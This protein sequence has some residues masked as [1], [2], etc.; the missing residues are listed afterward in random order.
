MPDCA[1]AKH[2][3]DLVHAIDPP[4][5]WHRAADCV[6]GGRQEVHDREHAVFRLSFAAASTRK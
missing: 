3:I 6:G 5:R 2:H 4:V 1:I